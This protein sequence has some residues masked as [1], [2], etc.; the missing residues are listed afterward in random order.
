MTAEARAAVAFD[1]R[2][3]VDSSLAPKSWCGARRHE[4]RPK[5]KKPA[6]SGMEAALFEQYDDELGGT[7]PDRLAGVGPQERVQR[8]AVE[9]II[10]PSVEVLVLHMVES[11]LVRSGSLFLC[12]GW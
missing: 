12:R 3:G 8:H 2:D 5:G 1:A 11:S 9:Q 4:Q 10:V 6:I 7:R